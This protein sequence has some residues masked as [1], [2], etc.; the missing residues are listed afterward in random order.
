MKNP[1]LLHRVHPRRFS[2]V[3]RR[4]R[5]NRLGATTVEFALV[6]PIIFT[7]FLGA[8]EMTRMNFIKH[9]AANAAYEAARAGIIPGAT[10]ADCKKKA[11]D[12]LA[13]V[14]AGSNVV[15]AYESTTQSVKVT[16]TI[17]VDKN[18]WAI[19]RFTHGMNLVQSC[20]LSREI[21]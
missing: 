4:S 17:P 9:S 7:M 2:A 1:R 20:K 19:G 18:S 6:V 21:L 15:V 14:G 13:A 3:S 8:I 16:V 12:L 11:T 10:E 5:S